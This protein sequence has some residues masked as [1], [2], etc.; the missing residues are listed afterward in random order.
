HTRFSRDWSS[1]VC[2]SDLVSWPAEFL[3][4]Y[5]LP[6]PSTRTC[7]VSLNP[8][9]V[10]QRNAPVLQS[11]DSR[12]LLSL[13]QPTTRSP[14]SCRLAGTEEIGRASCREGGLLADDS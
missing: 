2:S 5:A 10:L 4:T 11:K 1:D 6:A 9:S 7:R 12:S 8:T 3:E 13:D 14:A